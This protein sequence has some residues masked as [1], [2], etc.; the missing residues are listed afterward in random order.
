MPRVKTTPMV[1]FALYGL[2]V[3]LLVLLLLILVKFVRA[4]GHTPVPAATQTAAQSASQPAGG[5]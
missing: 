2:R 1:K 4:F 5:K 3:Y